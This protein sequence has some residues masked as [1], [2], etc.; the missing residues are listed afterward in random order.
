MSGTPAR[1]QRVSALIAI[2]AVACAVAFA[3]G[4]ILQGRAPTYRLLCVGLLSGVVAWASERRGMLI[5]TLLSAIGLLLM[6]GWIVASP[7]LWLGV[8]TAE[9]VHTF[10][11]LATQIGAQAREYVS[12]APA[13]PALVIAGAIAVW[14]AIF[15]CYALAF[16][17]QSPLLALA[18]TRVGG[19]RRRVWTSSLDRLWRRLRS[20]LAVLFADLRDGCDRPVWGQA[21]ARRLWPGGAN[22][23]RVGLRCCCRWRP[24]AKPGF[25]TTSVRSLLG[26]R[27]RRIRYRR[28]IGAASTIRRSPPLCSPSG[29]RVAHWRA[30]SI[31]R[32][33]DLGATQRRASIPRVAS[34]PALPGWTR[35]HPA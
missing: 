22:A 35:A 26:R 1:I 19:V 4:R 13:T 11:Q 2:G 5:A 31:I 23:R 18:A 14:A 3:F 16:R 30:S 25:G 33:H 32:R 9:T 10:G 28:S 12:P 15:S 21:G 34:S 20:P 27:R 7:T 8:P 6:L 17:A 24:W 29:R